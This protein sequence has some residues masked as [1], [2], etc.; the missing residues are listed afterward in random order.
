MG[1]QAHAQLQRLPGCGFMG[2]I[3]RAMTLVSRKKSQMGDDVH[4][5]MASVRLLSSHTV[6]LWVNHKIPMATILLKVDK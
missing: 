5:P 3:C 6:T 4:I 2:Q 1:I